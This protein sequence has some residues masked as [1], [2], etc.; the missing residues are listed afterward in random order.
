MAQALC[1]GLKRLEPS[2]DIFF[3][4]L[5]LGP[6]FW[7]PKLAKEITNTDAFLFLIGP[8]GVGPWQQLEYDEALDRYVQERERFPLVPVIAAG[9]TAPGLSFLRRL[10]WVEAPIITGDKALHQLLAALKGEPV[11]AA[12]P[13]WKLV[14]P[15]RGLEAMTEANTDYFYGR[16]RET[17]AVLTALAEK[18][19]RCPILIGASGVGKSSVARACKHSCLPTA[20]AAA[21][22]GVS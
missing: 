12:T 21:W 15:Y 3:S 10:N 16:S 13:L 19:G 18:R 7:V 22:S 8:S 14:N 1:A 2:A 20:P 11:V 17:A 4:P 9:A 5:S 6:G